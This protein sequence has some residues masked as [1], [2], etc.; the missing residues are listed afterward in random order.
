MELI[1]Y[2]LASA[3]YSVKGDIRCCKIERDATVEVENQAEFENASIASIAS[4]SIAS[5]ST[6]LF[7]S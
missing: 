7:R 2:Q 1:V 5:E 3:G 6:M 4:E